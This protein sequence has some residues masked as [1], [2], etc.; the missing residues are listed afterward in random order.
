LEE[1]IALLALARE[2]RPLSELEQP[3]SAQQVAGAV[4]RTDLAAWTPPPESATPRQVSPH[5][6]LPAALAGL[7]KKRMATALT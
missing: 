6:S 5:S 4:I 7:E 1:A 2:R 3:G